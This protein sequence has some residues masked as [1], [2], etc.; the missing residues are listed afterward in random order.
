MYEMEALPRGWVK[1]TLGELSQPTRP[2]QNPSE[3]PHL[4]YLGLEHVE[5]HTT[6]ILGTISA[7]EMKSGA[8]HFWPGDVLYGRLR[9]YLNKVVCP[10][11]EGM[12]SSEFIVF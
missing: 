3:F 11:F 4:R 10:D 7:T 6:R 9:P 2:R 8:V 5:A 12:G 1:T